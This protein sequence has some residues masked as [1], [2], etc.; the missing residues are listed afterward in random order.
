MQTGDF[1]LTHGTHP[2]S[3]IIQFGQSI[4]PELRKY[5]GWNH[6]ALIVNEDGLLS[7]ALSSGIRYSHI[8]KYMD[9]P[10]TD[11]KFVVVHTFTPP[12]G[13]ERILD[14]LDKVHVDRWEYGWGTIATSAISCLGGRR[15]PFFSFDGTAICSGHVAECMVRGNNAYFPR[16]A[17]AM[18]PAELG[19]F[20][21]VLG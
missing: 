1:I 9:E 5:S 6:A 14:Y 12:E 18:M 10:D 3:R 11:E 4:R 7:E 15:L 8:S 13:Q 20:Y 17:Q 16:H 19:L 21:N 2:Q